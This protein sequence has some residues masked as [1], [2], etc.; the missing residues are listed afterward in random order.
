MRTRQHCH[1]IVRT[2]SKH[3]RMPNKVTG[4]EVL[5]GVMINK[6]KGQVFNPWDMVANVLNFDLLFE[7]IWSVSN[8]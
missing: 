6:R 2:L 7:C 8:S 5:P 1:N 3:C 4:T